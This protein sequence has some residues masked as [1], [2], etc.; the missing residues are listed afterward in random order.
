MSGDTP[1]ATDNFPELIGRNGER[2]GVKNILQGKFTY[3]KDGLDDVHASSE[4]K[5][6]MEALKLLV[7]AKIGE[8]LKE[9]PI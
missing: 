9:I 2:E 3:G 4:M 5:I 8:A 7:S 1:F 6:F